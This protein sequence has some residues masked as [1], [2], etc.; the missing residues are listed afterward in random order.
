EEGEGE[1]RVRVEGGGHGG[2]GPYTFERTLLRVLKDGPSLEDDRLLRQK[3]EKDE[4]QGSSKAPD[5]FGALALG[6]RRALQATATLHCAN[7]LLQLEPDHVRGLVAR[8]WALEQFNRMDEALADY[9]K[10]ARLD[11]ANVDARLSLGELLLNFNRP[12]DAVGHFEWLRDQQ[13]D[14]VGVGYGLARCREA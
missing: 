2:D 7:E 13:P 9:Q 1:G 3:L 4:S 10:A 5:V 12:A 14:N 11:P 8:G 6:Y